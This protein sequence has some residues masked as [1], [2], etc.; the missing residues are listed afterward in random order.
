[1]SDYE[2][3]DDYDYD[4]NSGSGLRKQLEKALKRVEAAEKKAAEAEGRLKQK[5]A[6][7]ALTAKGYPA[8]VARLAIKDGVDIANKEALE[9]WLTENGDVFAKPGATPQ[10][11]ENEQEPDPA[12]EIPEGVEAAYRGVGSIH[13]AAS[14][15]MV[16]RMDAALAGIPADATKEQVR[17][18]LKGL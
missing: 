8:A 5:E 13:A 6:S 14:P 7:E 2:Y 4:S 3:D 15:A 10:N 11:Q 17:E 12:D 16:N 1:M 18:A 9:N